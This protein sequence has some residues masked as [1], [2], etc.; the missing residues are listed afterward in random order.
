V[1]PV[2]VADADTL[3]DAASRELQELLHA[4][5]QHEEGGSALDLDVSAL[6]QAIDEALSKHEHYT[7]EDV[8]RLISLS[9]ARARV[10]LLCLF[11]CL[12][13]FAAHCLGWAGW[14]TPPMMLG[15]LRAADH[16][17]A[18]C[19]ARLPRV[20]RPPPHRPRAGSA[21]AR[22]AW[23]SSQACAQARARARA[24]RRRGVVASDSGPVTTLLR[25]F[26]G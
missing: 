26:V 5:E 17:R 21:S 19:A 2:V 15:V 4:A 25:E 14:L 1:T 6:L 3:R 8:R 7:H 18:G 11:A 12:L 9:R 10:Y 23:S 24:Y 20:P 16:E 13:H 22:S